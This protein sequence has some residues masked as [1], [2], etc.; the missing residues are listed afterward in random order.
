MQIAPPPSG[1]EQADEIE[2][3]TQLGDKSISNWD[4]SAVALQEVDNAPANS[5]PSEE[6]PDQQ[7]KPAEQFQ[8][9]DEERSVHIGTEDGDKTDVF[10]NEERRGKAADTQEMSLDPKAENL[11]KVDSKSGQPIDQALKQAVAPEGIVSFQPKKP[12]DVRFLKKGTGEESENADGKKQAKRRLESPSPS[13]S[14]SSGTNSDS[15]SEDSSRWLPT[16]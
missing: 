12:K 2:S 1:G 6:T 9:K 5:I 7:V 13:S 3:K 11:D 4:A 16:S 8:A 15:D 10:A 14:T